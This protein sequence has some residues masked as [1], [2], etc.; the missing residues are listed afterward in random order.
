MAMRTSRGAV[1][2]LFS[3]LLICGAVHAAEAAL[4]IETWRTAN[5]AKVLFVAVRDLPIVDV[6]VEFPAGSSRDPAGKAGLARLTLHVMKGGAGGM[7][8]TDI[9]DRLADVGAVLTPSIDMDRAGY[10][11]RS[12]SAAEALEQ[13]LAVL[14]AVLA[15]PRFDTEVFERERSRAVAG[16]RES[17]ARPATIAEREFF[18]RVFGAHPYG[19]P[20]RSDP[21]S[22]AA[23][24]RVDLAD[25]HRR[26]Y[27]AE[28]A[29]L[30]IIGD[31][32]R[33]E[34]G[35][36]AARLT[37]R[38][39]RARV[40]L[41]VLPAVPRAPDTAP[42]H[43]AHPASQAHLR[44]GAPGMRRGDPDY[45]A[46]WLGNQ[47]LGGG[48]FSSRLTAEL[49]DKRGLTYSAY[50]YFAPY[51]LEGP[52][53]MAAQTRR[54]QAAEALA[55]M[56]ATLKQFVEEGP[57]EVELEAARQNVVGGFV[58]RVDSNQ[59]ILEYLA[60]IGF[61]DL[62]L[63]YIEQFPREIQNVTL[64]QVRDA[65][66]RRVDPEKMITVVVGPVPGS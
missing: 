20:A 26:H 57:T 4:P 43:I 19:S 44:I 30:A 25:F 42:A 52:F 40:P 14:E 49:R 18:R 64:Q 17:L 28:R 50:S 10:A 5:G 33:A 15:A 3:T 29:V 65:F 63:D 16:L 24:A 62:S 6:S 66:R 45:Y 23:L 51:A 32:S 31:L 1:R 36:I 11:L 37:L 39:P 7:S 56:R 27:V 61:Y 9:S 8:E 47:I 48:G 46:L 53:V 41:T 12:L 59:K 34:A 60:L 58:L 55:V 54:E 35:R 22:I 13:G 2:A 38:L 21:E